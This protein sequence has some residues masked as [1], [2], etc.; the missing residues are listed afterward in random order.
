MKP[1]SLIIAFLIA[2]LVIIASPKNSGGQSQK[3]TFKHATSTVNLKAISA[4]KKMFQTRVTIADPH[5]LKA[6]ILSTK[7]LSETRVTNVNIKA[8]RHFMRSYKNILDAKWYT[9]ES[10]F[11]AIFF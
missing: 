4:G 10:G 5:V 6:F 2:F 7:I 3:V 9:T 11:T 8:V 1:R